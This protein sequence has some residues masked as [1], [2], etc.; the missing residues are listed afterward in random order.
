MQPG[1]Q[2]PHHGFESSGE[3]TTTDDGID[4]PAVLGQHQYPNG[5]SVWNLCDSAVVRHVGGQLR[6]LSGGD[7]HECEY[8]C[9]T[10]RSAA[11]TRR[12]RL[13]ADAA[14]TVTATGSRWNP[15]SDLRVVSVTARR[16][17]RGR[18]VGGRRGRGL[19]L[20]PGRLRSRRRE[21]PP[22]NADPAREPAL[23][24]TLGLVC[25][26]REHVRYERYLQG[27]A[28]SRI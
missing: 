13:A 14:A 3:T 17:R 27:S 8:E 16:P 28:A 24:V 2:L 11:V 18:G 21:V 23:A 7:E 6:P 20:R 26:R 10:G 5:G 15:P 4:R 1:D 25:I 12:E 19:R 9:A 22:P